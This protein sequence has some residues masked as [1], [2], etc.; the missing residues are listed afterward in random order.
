MQGKRHIELNE[1]RRDYKIQCYHIEYLKR[2]PT[3]EIKIAIPLVEGN[4]SDFIKEKKIDTD[5]VSEGSVT[6]EKAYL[7]SLKRLKE[8]Y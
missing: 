8:A 2:D 4:Y 5:Y 6:R 3:I 7:Q 1:G